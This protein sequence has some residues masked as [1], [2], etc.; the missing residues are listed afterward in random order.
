MKLL[1]VLQLHPN[2][3]YFHIGCDEVYQLG[4]CSRCKDRMRRKPPSLS[5]QASRRRKNVNQFQQLQQLSSVNPA[6]PK[7]IFLDH[8][9]RVATYVKD[10]YNVQPIIWDDM[11]RTLSFKELMTS[12][13]AANGLVEPMVWV[14][15]EDIDHFVDGDKW[16]MLSAVFSGTPLPVA[17]SMK[18]LWWDSSAWRERL[19]LID[20]RR[21]SASEELK[22]ATLIATSITCS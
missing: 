17:P 13:I 22:P 6:S 21:L 15:V 2:I 19:R 3:K 12:G 7:E 16:R 14:Y 1:Q 9:K 4:Q 10:N 20:R 11:L 5:I 8:V 18:R